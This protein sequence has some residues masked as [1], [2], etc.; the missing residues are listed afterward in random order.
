[1]VL[2]NLQ[3]EHPKSFE[4][5]SKLD[6]CSESLEQPLWMSFVFIRIVVGTASKVLNML[7]SYQE[8]RMRTHT[9]MHAQAHRLQHDIGVYH[10]HVGKFCVQFLVHKSRT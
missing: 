6:K 3:I 7:K 1:M 8:T 4:N 5:Q 2:C 9:D 10:A